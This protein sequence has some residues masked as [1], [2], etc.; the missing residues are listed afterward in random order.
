MKGCSWTGLPHLENSGTESKTKSVGESGE[1]QASSRPHRLP[2]PLATLLSTTGNALA[3]DSPAFRG[4]VQ[5]PSQVQKVRLRGSRDRA[6]GRGRRRLQRRLWGECVASRQ[7]ALV[8]SI[9][10]CHQAWEMGALYPV[11]ILVLRTGRGSA[12]WQNL[13]QPRSPPRKPWAPGIRARFL[14]FRGTEGLG[15]CFL[16]IVPPKWAFWPE[17]ADYV[18]LAERG[19]DTEMGFCVFFTIDLM[20]QALL[21]PWEKEAG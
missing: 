19:K 18:P 8:D 2:L 1:R 14:L 4:P 5:T 21:M 3:L 11:N 9:S 10:R 7:R 20:W 15:V 13:R 12:S 17:T 6:C 16:V